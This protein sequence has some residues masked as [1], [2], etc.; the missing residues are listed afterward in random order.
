VGE[1]ENRARGSSASSTDNTRGALVDGVF[2]ACISESVVCTVCGASTHLVAPHMEHTHTYSVAAL[3]MVAELHA[4]G[5]GGR[6]SLGRLLAEVVAQ[7]QKKC[8]KEK[9][10]CDQRMVSGAGWAAGRLLNGSCLRML[11]S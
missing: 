8:D 1:A 7:D 11:P 9:G 6:L 2:G 3:R 10:G 4:A 5:G